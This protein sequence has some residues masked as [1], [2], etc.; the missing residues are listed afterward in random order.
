MKKL[1]MFFFISLLIISLVLIGCFDQFFEEDEIES[2][3][4]DESEIVKRDVKKDYYP[5]QVSY[6]ELEPG[7]YHHNLTEEST[8]GSNHILKFHVKNMGEIDIC[9][10]ECSVSFWDRG[11]NTKAELPVELSRNHLEAFKPGDVWEARVYFSYYI[12]FPDLTGYEMEYYFTWESCEDVTPKVEPKVEVS[13]IKKEENA[14]GKP[15]ARITIKNVG[16]VPVQNVT[17]EVDLIGEGIEHVDH[18][19][20]L[21][22]GGGIIMPGESAVGTVVF[23]NR[24]RFGKKDLINVFLRYEK[25][26]L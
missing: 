7:E 13:S 3:T 15:M 6:E 10:I 24:L 18:G 5:L 8:D 1:S 17:A 2:E 20:I 25:V 14:E 22:N 9:K 4:W 26:P 16:E 19:G 11:V 12:D 23:E 21:F